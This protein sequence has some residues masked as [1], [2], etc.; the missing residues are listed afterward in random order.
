MA[1]DEKEMSSI[2]KGKMMKQF[3][4]YEFT[5]ILI[6]GVILI[7][8]SLPALPSSYVQFFNNGFSAAIYLIAVGYGLGHLVQA[9]GNILEWLFWKPFCGRPTEWLRLRQSKCFHKTWREKVFAYYQ[10]N[11]NDEPEIKEWNSCV[12]LMMESVA[13]SGGPPQR[14]VVFNGNYG[15]FRGMA[16]SFLLIGLVHLSYGN[17]TLQGAVFLVALFILSLYR[18]Y[19]FGLYYATTLFATFINSNCLRREAASESGRPIDKTANS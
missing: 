12:R 9:V 6:P 11:D 7:T 14:L 19:R 5:G 15:M 4:L 13:G 1:R 16:A 2:W 18:M 3:D 17:L 8:G 10:L